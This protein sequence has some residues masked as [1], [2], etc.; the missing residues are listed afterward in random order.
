M[1]TTIPYA[2]FHR[3]RVYLFRHYSLTIPEVT[4]LYKEHYAIVVMEWRKGASTG[5]IANKIYGKEG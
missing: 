3:I 2:V 5:Q 1:S 4:K